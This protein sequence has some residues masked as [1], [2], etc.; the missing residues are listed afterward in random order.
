VTHAAIQAG[1]V[2]KRGPGPAGSLPTSGGLTA[3]NFSK[4]PAPCKLSPKYIPLP[5]LPCGLLGACPS[6]LRVGMSLTWA[7]LG[8]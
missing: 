2:G 3:R 1:T 4:G 6:M 7:G 8:V 5:V